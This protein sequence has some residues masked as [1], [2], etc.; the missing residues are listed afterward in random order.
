MHIH[1]RRAQSWRLQKMNPYH[2]RPTECL[3]TLASSRAPISLFLLWKISSTFKPKTL[4]TNENYVS[5]PL[6]IVDLDQSFLCLCTSKWWAL[7]CVILELFAWIPTFK[8]SIITITEG[9]GIS[10]ASEETGNN[11]VVIVMVPKKS[12]PYIGSLPAILITT[13][14]W[15]LWNRL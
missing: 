3:L 12:N 4:I 11:A 5:V 8:P 15:T 2:F 14:V 7:N 10:D 9:F 6:W 1:T 13:E